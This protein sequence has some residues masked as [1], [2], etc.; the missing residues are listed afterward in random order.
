MKSDKRSQEASALVGRY[1]PHLVSWS[2]IWITWIT[3]WIHI[4]RHWTQLRSFPTWLVLRPSIYVVVNW[5]TIAIRWGRNPCQ[6]NQLLNSIILRFEI[7]EWTWVKSAHNLRGKDRWFLLVWSVDPLL[8][9]LIIRMGLPIYHK[10][11]LKHLVHPRSPRYPP[12]CRPSQN[13]VNINT[14]VC[15][16]NPSQRVQGSSKWQAETSFKKF[17]SWQKI[18]WFFRIHRGGRP[19][20]HQH[21]EPQVELVLVYKEG[22]VDVL[23]HNPPVEVRIAE[24]QILFSLQSSDSSQTILDCW[25]KEAKKQNK[26]KRGCSSRSLLSKQSPTRPATPAHRTRIKL[27]DRLCNRQEHMRSWRLTYKPAWI[28]KN[29]YLK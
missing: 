28:E 9:F 29:D 4:S 8:K 7:S 23:L 10:I 12:A 13:D 20:I 27:L 25:K 5:K 24:I 21:V 19:G 6:L 14:K 2:R 16:R 11:S 22:L 1:M 15:R 3:L 17:E 26:K 18:K